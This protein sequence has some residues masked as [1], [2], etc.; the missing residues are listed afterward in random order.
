MYQKYFDGLPCFITSDDIE[1][2]KNNLNLKNAIYV[3]E[4]DELCLRAISL[5]KHHILSN[6]TF[7]WWSAWLEEQEDSKN[8]VV[9]RWFNP[10]SNLDD[11]MIVPDRWIRVPFEERFIVKT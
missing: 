8:I 4:T 3:D 1:W 2:C 9:D 7:S 10:K 6:S 5:C 11:S